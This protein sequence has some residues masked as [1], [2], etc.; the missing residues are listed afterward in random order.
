LTTI[1]EAVFKNTNV[2]A[3]NK[4]FRKSIIDAYN[5]KFPVGLYYED[6]CFFSKYLF[7]S[8]TIYCVPECLYTYIRRENSIMGETFRKTPKA[9]DH[10]KILED[11]KNFLAKN[12]L[13]GSYETNV[14]LWLVIA[15][16]R[17]VVRYG[18]ESIY[19]PAVKIAS[20]LLIDISTDSIK[21][22]PNIFRNDKSKLIALKNNDT[23]LFLQLETTKSVLKK[24]VLPFF[25][26]GSKR[27]A[28]LKKAYEKVIG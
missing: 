4:I 14:F 2:H 10:I 8:K 25:P 16:M 18:V 20:D 3:W 28:F 7:V 15:Y 5:I 27:R 24:I 21:K 22:C 23:K 9:I 26:Q 12:N 13:N 1:N 19:D 6:A 17:S 11:I